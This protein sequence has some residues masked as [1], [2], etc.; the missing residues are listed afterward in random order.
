MIDTHTLKSLGHGDS[1]LGFP[2]VN[3]C[4]MLFPPIDVLVSMLR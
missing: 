2:F 4:L 1:L 3:A